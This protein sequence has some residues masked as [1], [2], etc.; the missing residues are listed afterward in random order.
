M[1]SE[2]HNGE[3]LNH[4]F[5]IL[6]DRIQLVCQFTMLYNHYLA[7]EHDCG[8]NIKIT[9]AEART[10]GCIDENPGITVTSLARYWDKTKGA[11]SQTVS[12]LEKKGLVRRHKTEWNA[13]NVLLYTTEEGRRLSQEQ[14]MNETLDH[15]KIMKD[16]QKLCTNEEIETFYKVLGEYNKLLGDEGGLS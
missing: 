8:S 11:L 14:K 2:K 5:R 15:A 10:L 12:R 16:L 9:L 7:S 3:P 6:N 13:K 1:E 4:T